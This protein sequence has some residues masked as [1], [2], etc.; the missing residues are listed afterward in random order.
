M[1]K[2]DMTIEIKDVNPVTAISGLMTGIDALTKLIDGIDDEDGLTIM[3][4]RLIGERKALM[5]MVNDI[6]LK[7]YGHEEFKE[8]E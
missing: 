8:V 2:E 4:N 3:K 6:T 5:L 7:R 1:I